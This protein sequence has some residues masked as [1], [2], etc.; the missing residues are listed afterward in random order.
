MDETL[1][2]HSNGNG[3]SRKRRLDE[4][5]ADAPYL[6][7]TMK[8]RLLAQKLGEE[9]PAADPPALPETAFVADVSLPEPR[10]ERAADDGPAI[11]SGGQTD[12]RSAA[13]FLRAGCPPG[14]LDPKVA[15]RLIRFRSEVLEEWL[16]AVPPRWA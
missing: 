5:F 12:L 16:R 10:P 4:L 2:G 1:N 11:S 6:S 7:P 15:S 9:E 13:G 14:R 3:D 8:A